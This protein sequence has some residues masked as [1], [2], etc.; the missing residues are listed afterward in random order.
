MGP[1]FTPIFANWRGPLTS[2]D[3]ADLLQD[4]IGYHERLIL[5][6]SKVLEE[7]KKYSMDDLQVEIDS[8]DWTLGDVLNALIFNLDEDLKALKGSI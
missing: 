6:L 8:I 4:S 5:A 3:R 1:T 2:Y 7:T